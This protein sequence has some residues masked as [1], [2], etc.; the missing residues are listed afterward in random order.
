MPI[1]KQ[2][3][4][5][6]KKSMDNNQGRSANGLIAILNYI[7]KKE[8]SVL[9]GKLGKYA[10]AFSY[11]KANYTS[12]KNK[13]KVKKVGESLAVL[14]DFEK[15]LNEKNSTGKTNYQT[16]M[17]DRNA[18]DY[19][20]KNVDEGLSAFSSFLDLGLDLEKMKKDFIAEE[21]VADDAPVEKIEHLRQRDKKGT[22]FL[23]EKSNDRKEVG[24]MLEILKEVKASFEEKAAD[25]EN[26]R[27][28]LNNEDESKLAEYK[29]LSQGMKKYVD[30]IDGIYKMKEKVY[31]GGEDYTVNTYIKDVS[32]IQTYLRNG[33]EKTNFSKII[34]EASK[35]GNNKKNAV[36]N[37]LKAFEKTMKI[38]ID[39]EQ[40]M[41]LT[42]EN[43]KKLDDAKA[44]R[45]RIINQKQNVKSAKDW[46]ELY[47]RAYMEKKDKK[48]EDLKNL[49]VSVFAI[50][51]LVNAQRDDVSGLKE[52][53]ASE[54]DVLKKIEEF[55]NTKSALTS[56]VDKFDTDAELRDKVNN[57]IKSPKK[58]HGGAVEEMF[59]KHLLNESTG[60]LRNDK[61]MERYLPKVKDRIEVLQERAKTLRKQKATP[62]MEIAEILALR[63]IVVANRKDK[64]SL[65][66]TIP[67]EGRKLDEEVKKLYESQ[68][69]KTIANT[70][71]VLDNIG[72]GHGGL[73]VDM[74]RKADKNIIIAEDQNTDSMINE[75][76]IKARLD[77]LKKKSG[78]LSKEIKDLYK[79]DPEGKLQ[80]KVEE[81][82]DLIAEVIVLN[83]Y[84]NS[85]KK[86]KDDSNIPWNKI[87]PSK[88]KLIDDRD[89]SNAVFPNGRL[90]AGN[91]TAVLDRLNESMDA[92]AFNNYIA[93]TRKKYKDGLKQDKTA[94]NAGKKNEN[95][96]N[97]PNNNEAGPQDNMN[98]EDVVSQF[99]KT[100]N[101]QKGFNK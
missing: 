28:K 25:L 7:D 49:V 11:I 78:E 86:I 71:D 24:A 44:E 31:G 17:D 94:V 64:S 6:N 53:K 40:A 100:I 34:D 58:G 66:K 42:P 96:K 92:D 26:A 5:Q 3:D 1:I 51:T 39:P 77:M 72:D 63:N 13:E 37:G 10:G 83:E 87:N 43:Q 16:I 69:F 74:L 23:D 76:T 62:T 35:L 95:I 8:D 88:K 4:L 9:K 101:S 54:F 65:N 68:R 27:Y 70:K 60:Y 41:S 73:M 29:S 30:G 22:T 81:A 15:F 20:E 97:V 14:S 47:Q 85:S 46:I 19:T 12:Q 99:K 98:L 75:G 90:I 59:K 67:T 48:P 55:K 61:F 38:G 36:F 52:K 32:D 80:D 82:H 18:D 57:A 2:Q 45:Q 33:E 91:V 21:P 56:Y 89:Y 50:R 93:D 79:K 84:R